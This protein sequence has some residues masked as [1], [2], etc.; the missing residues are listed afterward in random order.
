MREVVLRVPERA[1]EDVLD[2]LL[3]IVPGGVR[4]ARV[5][6]EVELRMR[7]ADV[8][9]ARVLARIAG[10]WP[11]TI[12]EG[13]VSDDWRERRVADYKPE[14]IGGRLVVRPEWAPAPPG[15]LIDIVLTEAAAFGGGTHPTT[16]T[17]LEL[18]LELP[19]CGSFADLGCGTAV[20]RVDVEVTICTLR[21]AE[22]GTIR[23][24]AQGI[25]RQ[26]AAG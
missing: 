23:V 4:E 12:T 17:C 5:G 8:P 20:D 10:T 6:G 15:E 19:P 7:G 16:R 13:E 14:V 11:N 18:L 21:L 9:A 25:V 22:R 24:S 26:A 1:V 2:R 3:P